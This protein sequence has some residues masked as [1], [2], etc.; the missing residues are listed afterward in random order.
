MNVYRFGW[1]LSGH[2]VDENLRTT[3]RSTA[4]SESRDGDPGEFSAF[5]ASELQRQFRTALLIARLSVPHAAAA[6]T[7]TDVNG[8]VAWQRPIDSVAILPVHRRL[9]DSCPCALQALDAKG[10]LLEEVILELN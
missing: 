8:V 6:V 2:G 10:S 4:I 9:S 3:P 7:L 1:P 5:Y